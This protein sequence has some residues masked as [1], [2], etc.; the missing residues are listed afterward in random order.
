MPT[1]TEINERWR[2][3]G[4][5]YAVPVNPESENYQIYCPECDD[6]PPKTLTLGGA[7]NEALAHKRNCPA[8]S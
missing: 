5:P 2:S 6:M 1:L 3:T 4:H 7:M 8:V